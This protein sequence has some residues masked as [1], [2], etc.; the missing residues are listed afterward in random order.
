MREEMEKGAQEEL[1]TEETP[2]IAPEVEGQEEAGEEEETEDLCDWS[3]L[4]NA[5]IRTKLNQIAKALLSI[6][7]VEPYRNAGKSS[8]TGFRVGPRQ[9][10]AC[11]FTSAK[12]ARLSIGKVESEGGKRHMTWPKHLSFA[13][14]EDGIGRDGGSLNV[15]EITQKVRSCIKNRGW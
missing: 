15:K 13:V 14:S 6:K 11:I 10:V 3:P 1:V 9:A 2:E 5:K 12:S 8:Y 7:G 4:E